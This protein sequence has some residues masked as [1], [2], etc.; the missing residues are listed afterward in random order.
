[1]NRIDWTPR[2]KPDPKGLEAFLRAFKPVALN[3]P[4][5]WWQRT[6]KDKQR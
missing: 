2:P 5:Q 3:E 6:P 1:M 4:P